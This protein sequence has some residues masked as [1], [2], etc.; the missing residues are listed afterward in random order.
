MMNLEKNELQFKFREKL[1][2]ELVKR[3]KSNSRYSLRAFSRFLEVEP[4]YLSKLLS[5]KRNFTPKTIQ[6][7][8]KNLGWDFQEINLP[9][10]SRFESLSEDKFKLLSDWYY[11]AI[12]ELLEIKGFKLSARSVS[13][14]LP[15][16]LIQAQDAID[17]L[18]RLGLIK[19][20]N[21]QWKSQPNTTLDMGDTSVPLRVLQKQLLQLAEQALDEV[22]VS[23]RDQSGVTMAIDSKL[24]PEAKERIKKFR[25]ELNAFLQEGRNCDEVYQ[26]TISFFPLTTKEESNT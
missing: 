17:R 24:L 4:A 18:T 22:S 7:F 8:C 11:F 25:R 14:R 2:L 23:R 9:N 5:A 12:L 20:V 6:H 19:K 16:N 26:L 21:E 1:R 15:I 10:H 3:C 13:K